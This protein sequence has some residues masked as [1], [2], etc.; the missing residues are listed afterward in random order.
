[1]AGV[2]VVLGRPPYV[3]AV[4]EGKLLPIMRTLALADAAGR[5]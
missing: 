1:M 3:E 5:T 4:P 2:T